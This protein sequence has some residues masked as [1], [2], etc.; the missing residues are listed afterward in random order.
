MNVVPYGLKLTAAAA[1]LLVLS[2]GPA[3]GQGLVTDA[4]GHATLNGKPVFACWNFAA[5][6]NLPEDIGRY[7]EFLPLLRGWDF[8]IN[9]PHTQFQ[10]ARAHSGGAAATMVGVQESNATLAAQTLADYGHVNNSIWVFQVDP[11]SGRLNA[12]VLPSRRDENGRATKNI[13]SLL[14]GWLKV[15]SGKPVFSVERPAVAVIGQGL[16]VARIYVVARDQSGG[17]HMTSHTVAGDEHMGDPVPVLNAALK[18]PTVFDGVWAEAWI[19]LGISSTVAPALSETFD[20]KLALAWVDAPTGELRVQVYSPGSNTWGPPTAIAGAAAKTPQLVW[21]GVALNL[22]FIDAGSPIL[23][24]AYALSDDPLAFFARGPVSSLVGVFADQFHAMSFHRRLHVVIRHDNGSD[25]GP[26]FYTSSTTDPGRPATWSI[27]SET[28]ISTTTAPRVAWMYENILV[29]GTAADG[30]VRYARKDPN[31][32]GNAETG[33]ALADRWL[34]PGLDVD[35]TAPGSFSGVETL[36][37]NSDVYLAA[38]SSGGA[39]QP[40]G[41]HVVNLS[42]A[43]LKRLITEKWGMRLLWGEPGG[44]RIMRPGEFA[45]ANEVPVIGD[46]NGDGLTDLIRFTQTFGP[47]GEAP[48]YW[49]RNINGT[50]S[51]SPELLAPVLSLPGEVPMTGD[52]DGDNKDDLIS[53][54]Q[55]PRYDFDGNLIATAPVWVRLS[56]GAQ[57]GVA[58]WHDFFSPEGEVPFVGDFN[59]D[60]KDDIVSFAQN[61]LSDFDGHLIAQAPVWVALSDGT[62]FGEQMRWHDFFSPPGEV[63]MVG[64]FSGDGKDDIVT[65]VQQP[66]TN[67]GTA[68]VYVATSNGSQFVNSAVWHTFFSP[69]PEVPQVADMNMDGRDDIITFLADKPGAGNAAR[70][71]FVAFSVGN[72]FERSITW[73]SDFITKNQVRL[74]P[75]KRVYSPHIG[76]LGAGSGRITLGNWTGVPADFNRPVPDILAFSKDGS[77]Q[78]ARTMSNVPY[79][80]GAPWERYKFFTDKGI[81]VALFPEW[82]YEGPGHCIAGNHRFALNG[83]GGVGGGDLTVTSVRFGGRAPHILEELGHSI[84]ANCFR[85]NKDPFNLFESIFEVPPDQGGI[86]APINGPLDALPGCPDPNGF[87]SCRPDAPGEHYFLQLFSRYRLNP[88]FF[89][90]RIAEET[91]P[92]LQANLSAHYQWFKQNWYE[93]MEF[94]TSPSMNVSLEQPGVPLLPPPLPPID[95]NV[96]PEACS[97]ADPGDASCGSGA[98]CGGA[99]PLPLLLTLLTLRHRPRTR[100]SARPADRSPASGGCYRASGVA[101]HECRRYFPVTPLS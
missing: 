73:H 74:G 2:S 80:S 70:S 58:L 21:D 53:F 55:K 50:I 27:P 39:G 101:D 69:S 28:G 8:R 49:H 60:G 47:D 96:Q 35:P 15:G 72:R 3:R 62:R 93:G 43:A 38:N 68:P 84:F 91:D 48:V 76:H 92:T 79:P 29:V 31:R 36:T 40:A 54:A 51:T 66:Q 65:F 83:S 25:E 85:A 19:P 42:R 75:K 10:H 46:V 61:P 37:F 17:L 57:V 32:P 89:R 82:V 12:K 64:D 5:G 45:G 20:G 7:P 90:R 26:I 33:A 16:G 95:C 14:G 34:D 81:G 97:S 6:A 24:R 11:A 59:G 77:V 67:V 100:R 30:R 44:A 56:S 1:V 86:G 63:P 98:A 88:E 71:I 94:A 18:V 52:F 13:A 22:L 78:T 99:T 87:L 4:A 23:Q 41:L 9:L